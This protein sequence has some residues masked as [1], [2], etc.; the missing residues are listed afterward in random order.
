MLR[1]TNTANKENSRDLKQSQVVLNYREV[2][3]WSIACAPA[4]RRRC[5]RPGALERQALGLLAEQANESPTLVRVSPRFTAIGFADDGCPGKPMCGWLF[6][7]SV[8]IGLG[9][10][11]SC[12]LKGSIAI[13]T[14]TASRLVGSRTVLFGHVPVE[15]RR[16]SQPQTPTTPNRT[17]RTQRFG[18]EVPTDSRFSLLPRSQACI[19]PGI[20]L[21]EPQLVTRS[22]NSL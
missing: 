2:A 5:G 16:T 19:R 14:T 10:P 3:V 7:F 22:S 17:V 11:S 12:R 21:A 9:R 20:G 13:A 18:F 4:P 1:T 15:K 6:S 8:A